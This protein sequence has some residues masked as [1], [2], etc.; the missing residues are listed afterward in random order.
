[1]DGV[2]GQPLASLLEQVAAATPAPGGG[3]SAACTCALGA[4]LAEMAARIGGDRD[5]EAQRLR[6]LRAGALEL[7]EREL[8]S[9]E[10]V[11]EALRLPRDDPARQGR[12]DDAL[13]EASLAPLAIAEA[14]GEVAE[15]GA[16]LAADATPAVRGDAL[17]GVLLAE[18]AAATATALVAI[19]LEGHPGQEMLIRAREASVRAAAARAAV[20]GLSG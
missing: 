9:Y 7:A 18:A 4:A 12:L 3:S 14:A 8:R 17:A 1:M 2:A 20:L 15:L 5:V 16:A 6:A 11:L 19:N 13:A 10:P